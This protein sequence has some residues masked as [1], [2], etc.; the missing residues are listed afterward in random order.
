MAKPKL[1]FIGAGGHGQSVADAAEL[2]DQF[3]VLGF[4]NDA[5]AVGTL[6]LGFPVMGLP[7]I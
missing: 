5:L 2:N 4:F 1:L 3:E 6:V 7:L